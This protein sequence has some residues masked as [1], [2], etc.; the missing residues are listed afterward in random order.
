MKSNA[1]PEWQA[2]RLGWRCRELVVACPLEGL[3]RH[4][5]HIGSTS[6]AKIAASPVGTN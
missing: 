1:A 2:R 4:N 6:A 5:H 3:V